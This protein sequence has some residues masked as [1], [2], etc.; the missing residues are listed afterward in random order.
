MAP[1]G[2]GLP[3]HVSDHRHWLPYALEIWADHVG[4]A[5]AVSVLW[6]TLIPTRHPFGPRDDTHGRRPQLHHP[7][8]QGVMTC[9]F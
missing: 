5:G 9:L 7:R 1:W 3:A 4:L 8:W 6:L 2:P